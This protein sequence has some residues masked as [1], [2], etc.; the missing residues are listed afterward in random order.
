MTHG[1]FQLKYPSQLI[2]AIQNLFALLLFSVRPELIPKEMLNFRPQTF[3][4]GHQQDS[5]E[6]LGYL[7]D[8]LHEAEK[9]FLKIENGHTNGTNKL[10]GTIRESE[11]MD[12]DDNTPPSTDSERSPTSES[13]V[14]INPIKMPEPEIKKTLVEKVFA[15][16]A[17]VRYKCLECSTTSSIIDNFFDLQLA[18]PQTTNTFKSPE[19]KE[20]TTQSLLND[21]FETEKL[22]DDDKY[23]CEKCNQHCDGERNIQIEQAPNNLVLF[24]KHFKYDRKFNVRQ[25]I[26]RRINHNETI[27]LPTNPSSGESLSVTYRLYAL[28]IHSGINL[29]SGHYYTYGSKSNGVWYSFNDNFVSITSEDDIKNLNEYNTPCILFYKQIPS[30]RNEN[31]L[32]VTCKQNVDSSNGILQEQ[33]LPP[34]IRDYVH[35]HNTNYRQNSNIN[36][37]S[38]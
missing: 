7:L 27:V 16:R 21:Y 11:E 37:S 15:G 34:L 32:Y 29:D 17:N 8:Q 20:T 33:D 28:V 30:E 23:F 5:F 19:F 25:K 2:E 18:V 12:W 36:R 22:I 10:N 31:S 14:P 35:R 24:I 3:L 6:Y 9:H 13:N 1:L 38:W 4:Y 26:L